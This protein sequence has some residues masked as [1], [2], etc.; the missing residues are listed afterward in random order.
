MAPN[1]TVPAFPEVF[2]VPPKEQ[3]KQK[4][5]GQLSE[6]Q[7]KQFFENG[8]IVLNDLIDLDLLDRVR[9]EWDEKADELIQS[10]YKAGKIK[11]KHEDKDGFSRLIHVDKE[12]P[13]AQFL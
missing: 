10:L 2:T 5:P 7:L 4:K 8:Y 12:Y 3:P 6:E 11:N 1:E 9:K 13:G